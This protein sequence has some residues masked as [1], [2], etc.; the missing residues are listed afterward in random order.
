MLNEG[1]LYNQYI[2]TSQV[3]Q[4]VNINKDIK[5]L[6]KEIERLKKDISQNQNPSNYQT[7]NKPGLVV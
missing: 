6:K 3:I 2:N 1:E 5:E 4:P 7:G